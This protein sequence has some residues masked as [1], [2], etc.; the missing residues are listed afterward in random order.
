MKIN[1]LLTN[2]CTKDLEVSKAFYTSLF[3]FTISYNSDWFIQLTSDTFEL[4]LLKHGHELVPAEFQQDKTG[5]GIYLTFVVDDAKA[6]YEKAKSL[7]YTIIQPPEVTFYGQN[8]FLI[9][10]PNGVL[11][12]VS[13]LA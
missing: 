1:R 6:L 9:T 2:I 4:G 7:G 10:D 11:V 12:D 8:R 13:S 3:D 5:S